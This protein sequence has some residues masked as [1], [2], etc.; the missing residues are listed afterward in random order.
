M[1][2]GDIIQARGVIIYWNPLFTFYLVNGIN[3]VLTKA[4]YWATNSDYLQWTLKLVINLLQYVV[5]LWIY[6]IHKFLI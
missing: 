4:F 1:G 3:T 6:L 5:L 2:K